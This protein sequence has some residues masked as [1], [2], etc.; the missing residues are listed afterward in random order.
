ML[1]QP[2]DNRELKVVSLP[3]KITFVQTRENISAAEEKEEVEEIIV[4]PLFVDQGEVIEDLG[5]LVDTVYKEFSSIC[6]KNQLD[7]S[8]ELE[9]GLQLGVKFTA[10][11][12]ISPKA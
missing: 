6:E 3:S 11:L 10:K 2:G 7:W 9:L 5:K 8:A 12:K 1:N 4:A